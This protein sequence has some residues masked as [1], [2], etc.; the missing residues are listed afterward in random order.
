MKFLAIVATNLDE[1]FMIRVAS[2]LRKQRTGL[3][4]VSPDGMSTGEQL[5]TV[6]K[7]SAEMLQHQATCWTRS[8]RP[9]LAEHGIRFIDRAAYTPA[10]AE[11]LTGY[12]AREISPVLTPLAF[13]PGHPFPYI[14]NLSQNLAVV[15]KHAGRTRFA[16]VKTPGRPAAIHSASG[17][18]LRGRGVTFVFLEDVV[19]ANVQA[20]FP[21]TTVKSAHLFRIVRDADLVIQEDEADDLLESV[22]EG[23][24]QRRHGALSMLQ[25]ESAMPRRVLDTLI[26]NFEVEEENV[27]RTK[28]RLGF[29]DWMQLTS[30]HRP[31]LKFPP[32][33]PAVFWHADAGDQVFEDSGI[34]TG[35]SIILSSRSSASRPSCA[36]RSTIRT[37]WRSR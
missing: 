15:V 11:Y 28:E 6:R 1:F 20:L 2:L 21:G 14:S 8:L 10:I 27:F 34:A 7:R 3:E 16:R 9:A 26:E 33:V 31:E 4:D 37:S 5:E 13:D 29:G 17:R 18:A 12:F 32:L 19:C 22:D 36:R 35:S 24:R 30:M 23:L 25:V